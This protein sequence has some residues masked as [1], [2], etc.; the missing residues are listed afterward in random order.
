MTQWRQLDTCDWSRHSHGS[1][2]PGKFDLKINRSMNM[3]WQAQYGSCIILLIGSYFDIL[4][5]PLS[6]VVPRDYYSVATPWCFEEITRSFLALP[7]NTI[8]Q[9]EIKFAYAGPEVCR[10]WTFIAEFSLSLLYK[11]ITSYA[12]INVMPEVG[13][14]GISWGLWTFVHTP[15]GEF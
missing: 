13:D 6:R 12:A 5:S 2:I 1:L 11:C 8:T 10:Y 7:L 9:H 14:H 4:I 3:P 15:R